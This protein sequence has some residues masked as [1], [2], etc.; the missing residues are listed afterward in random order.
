M[1]HV[2]KKPLCLW[3]RNEM[4]LRINKHILIKTRKWDDFR[5]WSSKSHLY[6]ILHVHLFTLVTLGASITL[7]V[8]TENINLARGSKTSTDFIPTNTWNWCLILLQK[9][10]ASLRNDTS[11][12]Q[13]LATAENQVCAGS[14]GE[15]K[16]NLPTSLN[17]AI[18]TTSRTRSTI[19]LYYKH[20]GKAFRMKPL[21][22]PTRQPGFHYSHPE[23]WHSEQT[24]RP[25]H[26]QGLS[27]TTH[28]PLTSTCWVLTT[29]QQSCHAVFVLQGE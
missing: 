22:I 2:S 24:S 23:E 11:T 15:M 12:I 20:A 9:A 29:P 14:E 10:A 18:K 17:N 4:E 6:R 5:N 25:A 3:G 1:P 19:F 21:D 16:L 28:A 13:E 8:N 7:S 26:T 27:I